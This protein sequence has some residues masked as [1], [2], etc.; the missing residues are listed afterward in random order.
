MTEKSFYWGGTTVG[1]ASLAPYDDDEFSDLW[2]KLFQKDRTTEGVLHD[3]ENEL[4]IT[5]VASPLVIATGAAMVDGKFYENDAAMTIDIPTPAAATRID[6]IVLRKEWSTQ[7]VR[8]ARVAGVEGGGVPALTQ[9]DGDTWEIPLA[10][11]SITIGGVITVTDERDYC[12]TNLYAIDEALTADADYY[13]LTAN[14]DY[15]V[16]VDG[17]DSNDGLTDSAAGA[18]LTIQRAVDEVAKLEFRGYDVT[19]NVGAGTYTD[20]VVLKRCN[21]QGNYNGGLPRLKGDE[22]TPSNV[23]IQVDGT[24]CINTS[25]HTGHW[26]IGGFKLINT[27]SGGCLTVQN[28]CMIEM[29]GAMDFGSSASWHIGV[30]Q[31]GFFWLQSNYD[32]TGSATA[33]YLARNNA[34]INLGGGYTVTLAGVPNFSVYFAWALEC[35]TIL[36]SSTTFAGSGAT[37]IRYRVELNG[38]INTNGGGAAYFPGNAA[39]GTATGG[40]YA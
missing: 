31:G 27:T 19:I 38:V 28:G 35:A 32:I 25:F 15:Y 16:R 20:A 7:T 3:Y 8:V 39:G 34:Y 17:N 14:R 1:D 33:H 22:A 5:G 29:V 12:T 18:F 13:I 24:S 37:G 9:N 11:A 10:Q 30:Y 6:R 26:R 4:E 36:A 40:Q 2:R 21:N 23:I